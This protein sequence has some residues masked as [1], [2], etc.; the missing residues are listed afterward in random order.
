[1]VIVNPMKP[2]GDY[3]HDTNLL[4][5]FVYVFVPLGALVFMLLVV[6]LAVYIGPY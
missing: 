1:M 6:G 3:E 4:R 2:N 5:L